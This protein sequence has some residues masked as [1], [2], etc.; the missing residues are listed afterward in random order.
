MSN[1]AA[2]TPL[3]VISLSSRVLKMRIIVVLYL[4]YCE[5]HKTVEVL[6]FILTPW[7]TQVRM[8]LYAATYTNA[9]TWKKLQY[10]RFWILIIKVLTLKYKE[11]ALPSEADLNQHKEHPQFL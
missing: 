3:H 4:K 11:T 7:H 9:S 5:K 2:H 1:K 10:K 8:E 6:S